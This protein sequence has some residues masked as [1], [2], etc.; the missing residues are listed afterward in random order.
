[1]LSLFNYWMTTMSELWTLGDLLKL[2]KQSPGCT[3]LIHAE[4]NWKQ[5]L[6]DRQQNWLFCPIMGLSINKGN[7]SL[8]NHLNGAEVKPDLYAL[9]ADL[10]YGTFWCCGKPTMWKS[11]KCILSSF[12][13]F[14][15]R[16]ACAQTVH[17]PNIYC[18][19]WW[20]EKHSDHYRESVEC[21]SLF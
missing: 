7:N 5:F 20:E 6:V 16:S 13:L 8:K 10:C 3:C 21:L 17:I 19:L 18:H 1:M 9:M 15:L 11:S 14:T 12:C 2:E 4:I